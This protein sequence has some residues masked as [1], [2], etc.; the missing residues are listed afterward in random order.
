VPQHG[1][2]RLLDLMCHGKAQNVLKTHAIAI[3]HYILGQKD[4]RYLGHAGP[5][6]H[7]ARKLGFL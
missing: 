4:R 1:T 2:K 3:M 5:K 7:G 6:C